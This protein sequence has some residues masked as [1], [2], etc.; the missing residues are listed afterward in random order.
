MLIKGPDECVICFEKIKN[1]SNT[2]KPNFSIGIV[3][4]KCNLV[5]SPEQI[6]VITHAF[7]VA[8]GIF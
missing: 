4:E 6:E 2:Y 1:P 5:F 3:C 8:R 7:N